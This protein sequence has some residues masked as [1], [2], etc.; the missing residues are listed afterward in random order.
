MT[1]KDDAIIDAGRGS[2]GL[3]RG[4]IFGGGGLGTLALVA[5]YLLLGG[6][7][8]EASQIGAPDS[9]Q[10]QSGQNGEQKFAHCKTGSDA[11]KY[12]DCR[13]L[14]TAKSVDQF[15][16][17]ELPKQANINYTQPG[18]VVFK[19]RTQS[20]C[21][22]ASAST[23][24]FYCPQD[25]TAYLD[26][27]F[28]NELKDL[29][30]NNA[31]LTQE[32]TVAH[33]FGHHIQHLQGNSGKGNYNKPGEDSM[34][35]KMELQADCY[36]GMWVASADTGDNAMLEPITDKQVGDAVTTAQAIGDDNIQRRSGGSVNPDK[37]THG[38]SEERKQAFL[39]GYQQRSMK[40]CDYP[41]T[42]K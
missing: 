28:F 34:A 16:S 8:N 6:D 18:L 31:P 29:G 1:F 27:S 25:Q 23:G 39:K 20:G 38:S 12:D 41:G 14:A 32:Y 36:A 19:D 22:A 9:W 24:P 7:P 35:V 10:D 3:G 37:W 40:A 33:E 4:A 21:G 2:G 26:T 11:N 30:G 15:W 17:G 13:V 5:I 42:M